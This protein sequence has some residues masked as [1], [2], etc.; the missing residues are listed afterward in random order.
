MKTISFILVMLLSTTSLGH[1]SADFN[2]DGSVDFHDFAE[3][4]AQWL[5]REGPNEMP[6]L[7]PVIVRDKVTRAG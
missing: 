2:L 7:K 3:F 1:S 4:S 5:S 6:R